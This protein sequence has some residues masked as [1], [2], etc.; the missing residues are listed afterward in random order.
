MIAFV[1]LAMTAG[2]ASAASAQATFDQTH[3]RRAEVN[4]RL[5][6][7]DRR[8]NREQRQGEISPAK[9]YRL[10]RADRRMRGEE[11]RFARHDNGHITRGEQHGLNRQ[12]NAVSH[13]IGR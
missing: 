6:N 7:Q 5:E 11:R 13:R 12:E 1:G 3:P 10:H 4:G 9:A 2:A 8:I